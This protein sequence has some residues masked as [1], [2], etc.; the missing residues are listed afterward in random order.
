MP[1]TFWWSENDA[2]GFLELCLHNPIHAVIKIQVLKFRP[3]HKFCM[4]LWARRLFYY[5]KKKF[6]DYVLLCACA[7]ATLC[8]SNIRTKEQ[9]ILSMG[10]IFS[11]KKKNHKNNMFIWQGDMK[12]LTKFSLS[13]NSWN[14]H[15]YLWFCY[16]KL[17]L[18]VHL[19]DEKK[20]YQITH[21][22]FLLYGVYC[23][24]RDQ[25]IK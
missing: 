25:L 7:L 11:H 5:F 1:N 19:I 18:N 12:K 9:E 2:D 17:S 6:I 10:L 20:L 8:I 3:H 21:V 22:Y 14:M 15:I 23:A 16:R 13:R 4:S 24:K